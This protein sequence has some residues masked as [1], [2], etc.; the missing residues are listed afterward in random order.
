MIIKKLISENNLILF[1]QI[2]KNQIMSFLLTKSKITII[3]KKLLALKIYMK[4]KKLKLTVKIP[5]KFAHKFK[6]IIS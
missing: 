1:N 6:T 5:L 4:F 2:E 3:K